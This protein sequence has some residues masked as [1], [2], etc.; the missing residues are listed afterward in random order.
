MPGPRK[1]SNVRKVGIEFL[2]QEHTALAFMRAMAQWERSLKRPDMT[3]RDRVQGALVAYQSQ[4]DACAIIDAC[5][6]T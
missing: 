5:E 6:V 2:P 1:L 4:L 3:E